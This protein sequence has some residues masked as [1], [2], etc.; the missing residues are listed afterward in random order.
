MP[1][2]LLLALCL[3]V[4]SVHAGADEAFYRGKTLRIIV[5]AP[6]GGGYDT[7]TRALVRHLPR[8]IPGAPTVVVENMAGA[9]T[10]VAANHTYRVARP[11]GLTMVNRDT[12][13]GE[14]LTGQT[15]S[16]ASHRRVRRL[17]PRAAAV[18]RGW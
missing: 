11:D 12:C 10:L 16:D 17:G 3:L 13:G 18:T 2:V 1:A 4:A 6:P 14:S 7:Y 15:R 5:G 8:H 9:G